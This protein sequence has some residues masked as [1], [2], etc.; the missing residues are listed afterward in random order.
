LDGGKD[1]NLHSYNSPNLSNFVYSDIDIAASYKP[2]L[3][4]I[5]D[6]LVDI[7][8][9]HPQFAGAEIVKPAN[10]SIFFRILAL[11]EKIPLK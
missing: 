11:G 10:L 9:L 7:S 2:F 8:A 6:T 5:I 1:K 3:F 4:I